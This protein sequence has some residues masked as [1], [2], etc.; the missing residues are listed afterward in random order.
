MS[1]LWIWHSVVH[2]VRQTGKITILIWAGGGINRRRYISL[3]CLGVFLDDLAEHERIWR[4]SVILSLVWSASAGSVSEGNAFFYLHPP[5]PL[6]FSLIPSVSLFPFITFPVLYYHS[7][8]SPSCHFSH[9]LS[10]SFLHL[11][12]TF[13]PFF[14]PTFITHPF[15]LFL[16]IVSLLHFHLSLHLSYSK[17]SKQR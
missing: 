11:F 3:Y 8:Y 5:H 2:C 6:F 1:D 17:L 13:K 10:S 16:S 14:S 9:Y 4:Y 12:S 7:F 15:C